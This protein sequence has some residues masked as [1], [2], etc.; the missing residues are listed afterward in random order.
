MRNVFALFT[1]LAMTILPVSAV[2][3]VLYDNGAYNPIH[4]SNTGNEADYQE[5]YDDFILTS[6]S[7]ITGFE[8]LQ[9]DNS[10][11]Y[12]STK[13][14]IYD[15]IP[16]EENLIFQQNIVALRT[17]NST[18]SLYTDWKGYNY[19]IDSLLINLSAG[20]YYLGLNT[21]SSGGYSSWDQTIYDSLLD[22]GRYVMNYNF[23]P[24]GK[25]LFQESVFKVHGSPVPIPGAVWLL[26]S[27]LMGLIGARRKLKK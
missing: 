5:L 8:W 18:G 3:S 7:I 25:L 2:S 23:P 24:P 17:P 10:M 6:D 26:T 15:G 11:I 22:N 16:I 27:G 9:H 19:S 14:T 4:Q 20:S 12:E 21:Y 1:F 13:V